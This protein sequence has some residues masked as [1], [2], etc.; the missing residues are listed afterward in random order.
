MN[1]PLRKPWTQEEFF[2]W[3]ERQEG[4]FEFDGLRPVA[5][6]GGTGGHSMIGGNLFFALRSRLN[7]SSCLHLGS[8]A[9]VETINNAVRYPDAVV[10]CTKF[11]P[12]VRKIPGIVVVFEVLSPSSG[13]TDRVVKVRE[14][15]AVSSIR[16]YVILE[17]TAVGLLVLERS[18]LEQAWQ[19]TA[20]S[21]GD[22]LRMPEIGIEIPVAEIYEGIEFADQDNQDS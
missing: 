7:G 10:T 8:D 3:A 16:R 18:S 22:I 6:T 5:M 17:A 9:G 11:D 14:Y 20:L 15:A 1:A 13:A 21:N 4:H 19:T 12:N 2:S